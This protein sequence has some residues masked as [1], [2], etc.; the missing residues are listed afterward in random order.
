MTEA[1]LSKETYAAV[2]PAIVLIY[3]W[4]RRNRKL[5]AIAVILSCVYA[6][7]RCWMLGGALNYNMPFLTAHQYL[8][9]LNFY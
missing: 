2:L 5:A 8:K 6:G 7:Y 3:A 1:M 9:L 4:R